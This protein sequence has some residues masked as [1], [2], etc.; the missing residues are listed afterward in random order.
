MVEVTPSPLH[1]QEYAILK[2]KKEREKKSEKEK[3]KKCRGVL[4][5]KYVIKQSNFNY[6]LKLA[7]SGSR[8]FTVDIYRERAKY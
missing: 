3:E 4:V 7:K 6:L 2:K 1:V 8:L 5:L